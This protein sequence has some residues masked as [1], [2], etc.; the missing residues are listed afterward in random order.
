MKKLIDKGF[1]ALDRREERREE[2][3]NRILTNNV[4]AMSH[5]P[6]LK[7]YVSVLAGVD[8]LFWLAVILRPFD[9]LYAFEKVSEIEGKLV[10]F[11]LAGIFGVG[12]WLTYAVFRLRFP[13]LEKRDESTDVM[14]AFAHHENAARKVRIWVISVTGGVLNLLALAIT[15][16]LLVG[17]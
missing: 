12:M 6:T 13:D 1:D 17:R 3:W 14:S 5:P 16:G 7:R 15:E 2:R 10:L 9:V 4:D 8:L 11:V